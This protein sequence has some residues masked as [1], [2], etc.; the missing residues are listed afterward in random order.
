ML[1]ILSPSGS[2]RATLTDHDDGVHVIFRKVGNVTP[3]YEGVR[4]GHQRMF[5][6]IIDRPFHVVCDEIADKLAEL[7]D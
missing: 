1:T 2:L 4:F 3:G 7:E 5:T 6:K